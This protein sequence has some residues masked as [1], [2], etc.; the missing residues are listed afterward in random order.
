MY[1]KVTVVVVY[2]NRPEITIRCLSSVLALDYPNYE[3][4]AVDNGSLSASSQAVQAAFPQLAQVTI[5]KNQ[6]FNPAVSVGL[7]TAL[8]NKSDYILILPN[9]VILHPQLLQELVAVARSDPKIGITGVV[10]YDLDN[11]EIIAWTGGYVVNWWFGIRKA[12]NH[13]SA[14]DLPNQPFAVDYPPIYMVRTQVVRDIGY[15]DAKLFMYFDELDYCLRAKK[16]GYQVV[17]APKAKLWHE[18]SAKTHAQINTYFMIRNEPRCFYRNASWIYWPTF[19]A[20]YL[21]RTLAKILGA[22]VWGLVHGNWLYFVVYS[23]GLKDFLLANYGR[24]SIDQLMAIQ[25]RY[26]AN[27]GP[28]E[29]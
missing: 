25:A 19:T 4:V 8:A 1:P 9:D 14:A 11:P 29:Q 13:H 22:G 7:A 24:G 12:A 26:A 18:V 17:M 10:N 6:G 3:V 2:F 20:W 23:F 28:N 15:F 5:A 21:I 27:S 16:A